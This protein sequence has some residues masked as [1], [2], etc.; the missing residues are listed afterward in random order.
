MTSRKKN[1]VL[2]SET[3]KKRNK[4]KQSKQ[5]FFESIL[6]LSF[7]VTP[8]Q[9]QC[10]SQCISQALLLNSVFKILIYISCCSWSEGCM[11]LAFPPHPVAF[12]LISGYLLRTLD[13]WNFFFTSLGG[14][15]YRESTVYCHCFVPLYKILGLSTCNTPRELIICALSLCCFLLQ[16]TF[17]HILFVSAKVLKRVH[18]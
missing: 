2:K 13:N 3:L 10:P 7:F 12:F 1:S 4:K 8:G 15:S 6:Y 16:R 18:I 9:I 5:E 14:S 11:M 17:S